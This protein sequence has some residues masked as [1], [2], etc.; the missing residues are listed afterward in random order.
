MGAANFTSLTLGPGSLEP[1]L[2]LSC[3]Y[4]FDNSAKKRVKAQQVVTNQMSYN[5]KV[6]IIFTWRFPNISM[7]I[8]A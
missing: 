4:M 7:M 3:R 8:L 5:V 1:V 6:I 2:K